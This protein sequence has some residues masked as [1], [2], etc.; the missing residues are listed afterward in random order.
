VDDDQLVREAE[1]VRER[2]YAPY[3]GYRVGA[4]LLGSDGRVHLG[5]NVENA[6][7]PAGLCAER[8]AL[9]AAVSAG[10]RRFVAL[11]VAVGGPLPGAPCGICRQALAEFGSDLRVVMVA[12]GGPRRTA[13]LAELLPLPFGPAHL[14]GR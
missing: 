14:D 9:A 2:A 12:V 1:A 6:S 4:A 13:T 5:V 10:Q 11:A 7:Y 3:S 8:S